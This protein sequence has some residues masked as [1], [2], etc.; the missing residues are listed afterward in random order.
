MTVK[1]R[2]LF[3]QVRI[4]DPVSAIDQVSDILLEQGVITDIRDSI[5]PDDEQIEVI[6]GNNLILAPGLVDLYSSSGQPGY[7]ERETLKSLAEASQAGG[8][9]RVAILPNTNPVIDNPS[10]VTWIKQTTALSKTKFYIW[11]SLTQNLEGVTIAE[12]ANL[13]ESGVIGFTDN[14]PHSN[15]QLIRKLLEYAQPFNLPVALVPINLQLRGNGV[16]RESNISIRLGL[17]G[18]PEIAET[19]AIASILEIVSLTKTPVHLMRISTARGVELIK[20]AKENHL[21]I[22][23]SVNWHHL[24]LNTEIV[25]SYNPNLRFEPP[26]ATEIDRLALI[27]GIKNNVIDAIAVDHTP[28]TYEEKTVA[29]AQAPTGA[30]GLELVLPLLWEN[31]VVTGELSPLELWRSLSVNP[32]KCLK[33]E[34]ITLQKGKP[35]ELTLFSPQQTWQVTPSQ[36]KSLS[37][38]TY[39][40][41]KQLKGKI[42][43][44]PQ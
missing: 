44:F 16:V 41:D 9:T 10:L 8:F 24:L 20:Q 32:L 39:W 14:R 4:L 29:F 25:A 23:A 28:Y 31:L 38:N 17:M 26:L 3:Q 40:L 13:A 5:I 43:A 35:A 33:K 12:L 15:L 6:D 1:N 11:G 22:T 27:K 2:Q 36:L 30:I 18:Y 37:S 42:I 34:S 19:I 21:P 7:E